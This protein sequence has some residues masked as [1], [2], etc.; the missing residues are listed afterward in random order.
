MYK[1]SFVIHEC[2]HF[3]LYAVEK[4][5]TTFDGQNE[6]AISFEKGREVVSNAVKILI[7]DDSEDEFTECFT[8]KSFIMDAMDCATIST[9]CIKDVRK[10]LYSF[11][12]IKYSVYESTGLVTLMLNS[13]RAIPTDLEVDV[14]TFVGSENTLGE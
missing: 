3:Q 14:D 12:E 1:N 6:V 9:I 2:L 7:N 10:V 4:D 8:V 5:F 13:S 11:K